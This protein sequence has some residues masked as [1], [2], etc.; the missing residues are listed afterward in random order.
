MTT[1]TATETIHP[2]ER[3]GLGLAPFRFVKYYESKYQACPGAPIQCGT[4]CDYCGTAIMGVYVIRSADGKEFKVGCDCVYKTAK[5]SATTDAQRLAAAIRRK[6]NAVK[7]AAKHARD[8]ARIEAALAALEL[9]AVRA[10]L[11]AQTYTA[12]G[13]TRPLSDRV[14]WLMVNAGRKGK[15]EAAKLIEAAQAEVAA[16]LVD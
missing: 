3:S 14:G 9:P 10:K 11:A 12:R 6:A 15:I 5:E 8:D 7:T 2:F 13:W 4:S 1:N 16:S